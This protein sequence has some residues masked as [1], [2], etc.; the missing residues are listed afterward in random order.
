MSYDQSLHHAGPIGWVCASTALFGASVKLQDLGQVSAALAMGCGAFGTLLVGAA[1]LS[2]EVRAWME[3]QNNA[4]LAAASSVAAK[5]VETAAEAAVD[6]KAKA[7]FDAAGVVLLADEVA[8]AKSLANG[9]AHT[10]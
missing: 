7:K 2:R 5:L 6:V 8:G 3:R 1:S 9:E 10:P 4:K